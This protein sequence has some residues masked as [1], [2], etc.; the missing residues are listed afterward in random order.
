MNTNRTEGP[1]SPVFAITSANRTYAYICA[2]S[3]EEALQRAS[4]IKFEVAMPRIVEAH[5]VEKYFVDELPWYGDGFFQ[6]QSDMADALAGESTA[7]PVCG[8]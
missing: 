5:L 7:C 4:R 8:R 1:S 6:W 2:P 3:A